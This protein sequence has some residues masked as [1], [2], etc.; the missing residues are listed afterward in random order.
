M[1]FGRSRTEAVRGVSFSLEAGQRLGV[2]GESGSGKTV[3]ALAVMGLLPE[4][5]HVDGSVRL[6]GSEIV[7]LDES[8]LARL[9]ATPSRWCSRSR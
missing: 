4:Y 5:A 6:G 9:R 8:G 3:T 1:S 7:G 2:I